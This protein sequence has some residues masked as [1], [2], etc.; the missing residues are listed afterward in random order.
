M[1][2]QWNAKPKIGSLDNAAHKPG[3]GNVKIESRKIQIEAKSKIG[4]L[5]NA[6]HKPG[7][8]DKKIE[9]RKVFIPFD[10]LLALFRWT[11]NSRLVQLEYQVK[12]KVGSTA[13]MNYKAGGGNVKVFYKNKPVD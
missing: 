4:S 2:L 6:T 12:S 5:D 11:W 7:G 1:K 13:N 9:S 3:G 10:L 8:G